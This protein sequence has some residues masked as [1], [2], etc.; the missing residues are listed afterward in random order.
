[1]WTLYIA[2]KNYPSWSLRPW[3]LLRELGIPF[4]ERVVPFDH[5]KPDAFRLFLPTG[6]VPCLVDG[7]VVIR[8][9]MA[10]AEY[11]AEQ[12][13]AVWPADRVQRAWAR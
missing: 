10:I 13:P 11:V 2:N 7:D 6:K 9:S 8:D 12:Y 1:M 5:K 4:S 3:V